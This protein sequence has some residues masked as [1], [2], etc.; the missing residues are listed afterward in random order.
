MK[1]EIEELQTRLTQL[2]SDKLATEKQMRED[3]SQLHS[4]LIGKMPQCCSNTTSL[5]SV[6]P[7]QPPW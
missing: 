1:K 4:S 5:V 2:D 6:A 7:L 3:L